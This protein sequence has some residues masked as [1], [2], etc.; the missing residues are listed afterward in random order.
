MNFRKIV[1]I[2]ESSIGRYDHKSHFMLWG[3]CFADHLRNYLELELYDVTA[4]PYGIM[5]N[6]LSIAEGMERLLEGREPREEELLQ[7]G[8]RWHSMMHH[9]SYSHSSREEALGAMR[10]DFDRSRG[11]LRETDLLILT[12]GTAW[13]YEMEGVV[14]NNCHKLPASRFT[15][16]RLSVDEIVERWSSLIEELTECYPDLRI[17]MTVSPVPHYRDGAHESRLSKAVLLL[18]IDQ[19]VHLFPH[20]VAYFPAYEILQDELRDYRFYA[21]DMAHP[22]DLAVSYIM[23][24]FRETYLKEETSEVLR[25]WLRVRG[26]LTHRPLT[27]DRNTLITYYSGLLSSLQQIQKELPTDYLMREIDR[28]QETI[29]NL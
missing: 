25:S 4:S 20:S 6:P 21:E 15:R 16:R 8:G 10:R 23:E 12:F 27:D 3:S 5:Y 26:Q 17:L 9:G 24:R 11:A 1:E 13:V 28:I 22:S 7:E 14:V 18:A 29:R 19:L 2:E